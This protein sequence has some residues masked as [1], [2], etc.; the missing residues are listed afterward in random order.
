MRNKKKKMA[1]RIVRIPRNKH[2]NILSPPLFPPCPLCFRDD[3]QH[4]TYSVN[5]DA[6]KE[7]YTVADAR[8]NIIEADAAH[9]LGGYTRR[10]RS[11]HVGERV[12]YD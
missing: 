5:A 9:N 8:D 3:Q 1:S 2:R 7:G 12:G 4:K 6:G 11:R 10:D